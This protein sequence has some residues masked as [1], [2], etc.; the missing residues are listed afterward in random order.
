MA[1]LGVTGLKGWDHRNQVYFHCIISRVCSEHSFRLSLIGTLA[2]RRVRP[3]LCP[4]P[5][6]PPSTV[7]FGRTSLCAAHTWRVDGY[8]LS[9]AGKKTCIRINTLFGILC[10]KSI[11]LPSFVS[12]KL[13]IHVS[14]D[15]WI[16][17]MAH[18][19]FL[20]TPGYLF[21]TLSQTQYYRI[22]YCSFAW[23]ELP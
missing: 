3:V 4:S 1:G 10:G 16:C 23:L 21:C 17:I 13:F 18:G 20:W 22:Y 19:Y 6:T 7:L 12:W 14:M 2:Y 8:V 9:P 15:S 5:P 11:S